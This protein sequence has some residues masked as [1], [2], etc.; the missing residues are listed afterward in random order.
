[1]TGSKTGVLRKIGHWPI[2]NGGA[3]YGAHPRRI[4]DKGELAI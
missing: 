1:L 3:I 4:H 2:V